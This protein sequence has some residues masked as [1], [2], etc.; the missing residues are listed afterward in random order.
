MSD[1]RLIR[2]RE[3]INLTGLSKSYLYQLSNSG[4]FPKRVKLVEGGTASAWLLS[5][6][7]DWISSR[8]ANRK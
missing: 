1:N 2:I 6:V 3:V 4:N 8:V 5:E 7:N